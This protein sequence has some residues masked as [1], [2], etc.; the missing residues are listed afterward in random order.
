[1]PSRRDMLLGLLHDSLQ[2]GY[3]KVALRRYLMLAACGFEVPAPLRLRCEADLGRCPPSELRRIQ[4][5]VR[6][7]AECV[8]GESFRLGSIANAEPEPSAG[9]PVP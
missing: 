1:M 8:S 4:E 5:A 6:A 3:W 9:T 7:W 2:R